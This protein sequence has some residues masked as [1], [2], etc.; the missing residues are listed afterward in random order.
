MINETNYDGIT[1]EEIYSLGYEMKCENLIK[2]NKDIIYL[3]GFYDYIN[4]N[5]APLT[6]YQYLSHIVQFMKYCENKRAEDLVLDDYTSFLSSVKGNTPSTKR[7]IYAAM[8]KF[9]KYLYASGKCE[10]YYMLDVQRP[11]AKEKRST[12]LKREKGFLT[13][14]EIKIFLKNAD[15]LNSHKSYR[16]KRLKWKVR[17]VALLRLFLATGLRCS[18]IFKLDVENVDFDNNKIVI[19]DKRSEVQEYDIDDELM[20]YL[21]EWIE[22]REYICD[23][24]KTN[25]L[26][27]SNR[28]QR[29]HQAAIAHIV[30]KYTDGIEG[31]RITPHKLRATYG[32]MVYN[33]TH[34][35]YLTQQAMGHSDPKTTELYIRGEKNKSRL[36][37]MKIMKEKMH[38]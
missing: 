5:L 35:V 3:R 32:T 25:A 21:R 18:A 19:T 38:Y 20:E 7:G 17:D 22:A 10:K 2:T 28:G 14:D 30:L 13:E 34:D 33:E 16:G 36:N 11:S 6:S 24:I 37:A 15:T 1:G 8:K 12:K 23:N 29:L 27:I 9:S 26:F 31:K 4:G